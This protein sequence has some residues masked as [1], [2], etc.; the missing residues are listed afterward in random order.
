[1]SRVLSTL[2]AVGISAVSLFAARQSYIAIVNLRRYEER[3]ER[4]AKH[5]ETAAHEL[6]KTR[7]TQGTSAGVRPFIRRNCFE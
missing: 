2:I 6:H 5:S 4:A 7:T 3:S 1:M